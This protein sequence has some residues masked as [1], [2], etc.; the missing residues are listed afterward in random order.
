M[1]VDLPLII[2]PPV[3][4]DLNFIFNSW[5]KSYRNSSFAEHIPNDIYFTFQKEV[6]RLLLERSTIFVAVNPEDSS[7][8]YGYLVFEDNIVHWCYVK[9]TYRKLGVMRKLLKA[10]GCDSYLCTHI[11]K[12]FSNLKTKFNV[13]Y[14]PWLLERK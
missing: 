13:V 7:Q 3:E 4:Q 1:E 14:H 12:N 10:T 5:L 11:N 2:R 8:V 6:I 9:F